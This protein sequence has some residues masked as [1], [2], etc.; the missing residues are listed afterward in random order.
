MAVAVPDY[1]E[2]MMD[3]EDRANDKI[4]KPLYSDWSIPIHGYVYRPYDYLLVQT[5]LQPDSN[6]TRRYRRLQ[7][8][9]VLG[10][11]VG[12]RPCGTLFSPDQMDKHFR[13]CQTCLNYFGENPRFP[14]DEEPF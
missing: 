7:L 3:A 1:G 4:I 11:E 14:E 10:V 6:S 9:K 2:S 12:K 8:H 13:T 5:W